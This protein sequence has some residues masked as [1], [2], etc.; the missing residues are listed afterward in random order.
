MQN[1]EVTHDHERLMEMAKELTGIKDFEPAYAIGAE[2][3]DEIIL[4]AIFNNY[5]PAHGDVCI[6]FASTNF[7]WYD[8]KFLAI[9]ADYAYNHLGCNRVTMEIPETHKAHIKVA[10]KLFGFVLEGR[11][12]KG[13]SSTEDLLIF[14]LTKEECKWY[15]GYIYSEIDPHTIAPVNEAWDKHRLEPI[16]QS[17]L[18]NGWQGRPIPIIETDRIYAL[19]GSHRIQAAKITETPVPVYRVK[20]ASQ[21]I[22][23][24]VLEEVDPIAAELMEIEHTGHIKQG[25]V[26]YG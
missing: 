10:E 15:Q 3:D 25:L 22:I 14:G 7:K 26:N 12:R 23:Q 6:T 19:T 2:I 20:T 5:R 9:L 13:F 17:M 1:W 16:V 11:K 24:S 4:A 18:K 8:R 21:E